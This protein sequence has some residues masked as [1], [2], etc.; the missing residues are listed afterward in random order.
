[1]TEKM[2]DQENG[3]DSEGRDLEADATSFRQRAEGVVEE[4]IQ[5]MRSRLAEL[6]GQ[7][8]GQVEVKETGDGAV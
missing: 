1:M 6:V 8:P 4:Q 7:G 2:E 5:V 3:Q